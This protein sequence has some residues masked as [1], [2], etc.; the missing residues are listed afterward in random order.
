MKFCR[1]VF[2]PC[3]GSELVCDDRKTEAKRIEATRDDGKEVET[4]TELEACKNNNIDIR[5]HHQTELEA[6][7]ST[8][9]QLFHAKQDEALQDCVHNEGSGFFT[10]SRVEELQVSKRED[11][12]ESLACSVEGRVK[13]NTCE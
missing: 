11:V 5:H 8:K 4:L 12:E 9:L 3:D 10:F 7:G 2:E 6:V 13:V 1:S